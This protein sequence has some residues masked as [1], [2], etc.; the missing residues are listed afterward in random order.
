MYFL[1]SKSEVA[2]RFREFT[3][4][5]ENLFDQRLKC[6]RTDNGGEFVN[7]AFAGFCKE[8]GI[9]HQRSTPYSPQQNGLTERMNRTVMEMACSMIVYKQIE[10][11]WWAEAVSSAV[12]TTNRILNSAHPTKSPYEVC[13]EVAPALIQLRVF[14]SM[15]YTHLDNSKRKKLDPKSF[16]CMLLGCAEGCKA[17]R[18]LNVA[19]DKVRISRS[20]ALDEREVGGLYDCDGGDIEVHVLLIQIDDHDAEG[21]EEQRR[22]GIQKRQD[23]QIDEGESDVGR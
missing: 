11:L 13:Y 4:V 12:F 18:V 22:D 23:I 21:D 20:V 5:A 6:I 10:K 19:A 7:K 3:V 8:P 14:G 9:V 1:A 16:K 2:Q 17:Y 15:G